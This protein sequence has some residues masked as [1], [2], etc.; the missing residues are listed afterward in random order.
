[1]RKACE[2][3][4][5]QAIDS[6]TGKMPFSNGLSSSS[7]KN[8]PHQTHFMSTALSPTPKFKEQKGY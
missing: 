2:Q 8:A 3:N 5:L 7:L 4:L 1:M 6:L